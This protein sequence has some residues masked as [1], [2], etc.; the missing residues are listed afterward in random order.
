MKAR[1]A[2]LALSVLAA[3]LAVTVTPSAAAAQCQWGCTCEGNACGCHAKGSGGR[4]DA[5][6][7]G[8]VVSG[9]MP[10][11]TT[12]RLPIELEFTLDGSV[13]AQ[14]PG[15]GRPVDPRVLSF[16]SFAPA[17]APADGPAPGVEALDGRW[18][19][20]APGRAVARHCSGMVVARYFD[21]D[22]ADA[23]RKRSRL[24]RI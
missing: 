3:A 22:A 8:C 1:I 7:T 18:E 16:A 6:G 12:M 5:G 2:A 4:C 24:L 17:S 15:A 14:S 9:C 20:V 10:L 19:Y 11:S 23:A 21:R 13:V